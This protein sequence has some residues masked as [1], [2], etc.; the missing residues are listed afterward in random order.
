MDW[1]RLCYRFDWNNWFG[2]RLSRLCRC[3]WDKLPEKLSVTLGYG[4][5]T[6]NTDIVAVMWAN[7]NDH[8]S[9]GPLLWIVAMLVLNEYMVTWL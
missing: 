6:I 7:L 3:R 1:V 5:G 8:T 4:P 9:L 2:F